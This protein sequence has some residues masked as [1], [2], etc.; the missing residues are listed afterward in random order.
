VN[1]SRRMKQ[2]GHV[3]LMREIKI[4]YT[5][6]FGE[7]EW[8]IPLGRPGRRWEGNIKI[9]LKEVECKVVY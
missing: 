5:I 8:R 7:T 6:P 1:K 2:I 9:D 4:A 3:A